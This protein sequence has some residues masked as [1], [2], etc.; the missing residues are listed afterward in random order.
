V[1]IAEKFNTITKHVATHRPD[2]LTWQNSR[3]LGADVVGGLRDLKK[4]DGPVLLTQ[5]S[6]DLLQ[7]LLAHDL[8]DELRLLVFPLVLG[9]GK[10]FFGSGAVPATFKVTRS[11]VSP[12]GVVIAS[13]ERAGAVKTGSFALEEPT[14]AEIERRKTLT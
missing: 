3:S 13:Y 1:D 9:R 11:T 14:P 12:S 10:R 2:T 4:Q 8:V 5:G 7:T 6:S